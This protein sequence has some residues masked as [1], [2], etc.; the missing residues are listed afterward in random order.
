VWK[1]S[2]DCLGTHIRLLL[3]NQNFHHLNL[4]DT[5]GGARLVNELVQLDRV[6]T[7][8][9]LSGSMLLRQAWS[10]YDVVV[11]WA[12][13]YKMWSKALYI[14]QL[15]LAWLLVVATTVRNTIC[16]GCVLSSG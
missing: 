14:V 1:P 15:L 11:Y 12:R 8:N 7:V 13:Y 10:E 6:P 16:F 3:S 5:A 4:C 2:I 9:P